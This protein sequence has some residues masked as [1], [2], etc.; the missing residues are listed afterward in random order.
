MAKRHPHPHAQPQDGVIVEMLQDGQSEGR[1]GQG[2]RVDVRQDLASLVFRVVVLKEV[3]DFPHKQWLENFN[4]LLR[5]IAGQLKMSYFTWESCPL[6]N[7]IS[8]FLC[9]FTSEK[10]K[11]PVMA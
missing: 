11:S 8:K 9:D 3:D 2:R 10:T 4:Y 1:E 5:N 6:E 7:T